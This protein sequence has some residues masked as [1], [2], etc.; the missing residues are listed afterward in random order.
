MTSQTTLRQKALSA[1][2]ENLQSRIA[3]TDAEKPG[4]H[5]QRSRLARRAKIGADWDGHA[6]N[7]NVAWP[8]ATALIKEGNTE[9]L[10]VAMYYRR[11]HDM[12]K[13]GAML[14]GSSVSVGDGVALDRH[15]H[16]RNNGTV[17][18]KH[19]RQSEAAS[20]DTPARRRAKTDSDLPESVEAGYTNVPKAWKGDEP[21]NNMIDAQRE[22]VHLRTALGHLCE[23]FELAC[24][25]GATLQ[26]VGNSAGIANR[27]GSMGAGRVLVHMA[28]ITIRDRAG[29]MKKADIAG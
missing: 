15:T 4:V 24:I 2:G 11:I 10:K 17:A 23:P 9:L 26:A 27:A 22:L 8:L 7:D 29:P 20:V 12:A 5:A 1:D 18:H 13:S 25:D 3:Y 16:I 21:V 14:G 28:L 19:V 6:A